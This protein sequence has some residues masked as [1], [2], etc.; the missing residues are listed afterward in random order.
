M[1]IINTLLFICSL[2]SS[3]YADD[4]QIESKKLATDLKQSLTKNLFEKI[5]KDGAAS[6]V[7]FC[8]VNVKPIAKDA[9][10]NLA[11]K[12]DFGRSSHKIR[13]SA[14][15]PQDWMLPIIE[16]FKTIKFDKNK[17]ETYAKV[18][19]LPNG[20]RIYAEPLFAQAQ[21]LTCHGEMISAE[22]H[23]KI[24][25]LYPNDKATG[26]KLNDFRGMIWIKEK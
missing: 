19:K 4:F 23:N 3:V 11:S 2:S 6:A 12:Y 21:C 13:N 5:E 9:A 7:E 17:I 20:K 16:S 15:E 10:K 8:N 25:Q 26:F 24:N 18:I 14:N 1:K 22:V